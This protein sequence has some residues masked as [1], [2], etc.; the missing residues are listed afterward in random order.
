MQTWTELG[1]VLG[2]VGRTRGW[3]AAELGINRRTLS[4]WEHG[5]TPLDGAKVTRVARALGVPPAALTPG[6]D[7]DPK[8]LTEIPHR[9]REHCA[10]L[11]PDPPGSVSWRRERRNSL[12]IADLPGALGIGGASSP[13]SIWINYTRN[14]P[15]HDRSDW[16]QRLVTLI[17]DAVEIDLGQP[18][19]TVPTVRSTV[20]SWL[21][22]TPDGV[23]ENSPQ[24][25]IITEPQ[26]IRRRSHWPRHTVTDPT[27]VGLQGAMIVTGA[28]EVIYAKIGDQGPE[29]RTV[30]ADQAAQKQ[31]LAA[32]EALWSHIVD[33]SRPPIDWLTVTQETLEVLYQPDL[34]AGKVV[35]DDDGT[36]EQLADR[37]NEIDAHL[38]DLERE[39]RQIDAKLRSILGSRSAILDDRGRKIIEL[40]TRGI[41]AERLMHDYPEVASAVTTQRAAI[42][43][44]ALSADY[45]D[46]YNK[47]RAT[48]IKVLP[49]ET[50]PPTH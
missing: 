9:W 28:T 41:H 19:R 5:H 3:L 31:I 47:V 32:G 4:N 24:T 29:H 7:A 22:A 30:T 43:D 16:D 13:L 23:L 17:R 26:S 36:A 46:V 45:P 49:P 11:P 15:R 2:K 12:D 35:I 38:R 44:R 40:R 21:H 8:L 33:R 48:E 37:R 39:R 42:D 50:P 18:V 27:Y 6:R 20:Y 34:D 14:E 25:L 1:R 10:A